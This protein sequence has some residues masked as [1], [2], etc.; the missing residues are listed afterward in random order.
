[1][2]N[3]YIDF[4]LQVYKLIVSVRKKWGVGGVWEILTL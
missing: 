4:A 2:F 3:K 1:M